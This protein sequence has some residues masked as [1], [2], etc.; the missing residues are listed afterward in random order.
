MKKVKYNHIGTAAKVL[1]EYANQCKDEHEAEINLAIEQCG[2]GNELFY[3][4]EQ[5]RAVAEFTLRHEVRTKANRVI[6]MLAGKRMSD[7]EMKKTLESK[8]RTTKVN[9]ENAK[10]TRKN[11]PSKAELDDFKDKWIY[12]KGISRGWIKSAVNHYKLDRGTISAIRK[13][14]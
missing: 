3:T 10:K 4:K 11:K 13:E 8:K 7:K 2:L 5:K 14:K 1:G 9:T 12:E 6:D